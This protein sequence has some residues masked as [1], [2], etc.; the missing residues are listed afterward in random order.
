MDLGAFCDLDLPGLSLKLGILHLSYQT[1]LLL[2]L[3]E[4]AYQTLWRHR[5]VF[6]RNHFISKAFLVLFIREVEALKTLRHKTIKGF[7]T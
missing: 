5:V 3:S 2:Y 4:C 1:P 7:Q 6:Y